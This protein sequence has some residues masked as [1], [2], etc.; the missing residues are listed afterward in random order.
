MAYKTSTKS[1]QP[2]IETSEPLVL[3]ENQPGPRGPAE[4]SLRAIDGA[5]GT[6]HEYVCPP[7]GGVER[8]VDAG[9]PK[10]DNFDLSQF[11]SQS[12]DTIANVGV[13]QTGLPVSSMSQANDYVRLHPDEEKYW[14]PSMC[15]VDVPIKGASKD[16]LHLITEVLAMRFLSGGK[17]QRFRLALAT[18]PN[19]R[20]FLCRVP[21]R[22][23]DNA[24]NRDNLAGCE[25][26][27]TLWVE[28]LSRREEG[29]DG[30]HIKF[31]RDVDAFPE[32]KWPGQSLDELLTR[33]FTGRMIT[34]E[35]HPALLRLIGAKQ[36]LS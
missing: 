26:A 8:K 3:A 27:K 12:A 1:Q 15:F 2:Q 22:N 11:R 13:L 23:L 30:Y 6:S 16:A 4:M 31:A 9:I 33:A 29:V 25:Q 10:P 17:I 18:K 35:D 28:M 32:P 19:D 34:S 20:F 5:T 14:S 7:S 24:W 36:S 21:S